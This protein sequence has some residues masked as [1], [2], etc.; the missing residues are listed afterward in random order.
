LKIV[1]ALES[2][3]QEI[4]SQRQELQRQREILDND[5]KELDTALEYASGLLAWENKRFGN[6]P[7]PEEAISAT[8]N[9]NKPP[10]I[11]LAEV[12]IQL[13]NDHPDWQHANRRQQYDTILE[14]L[15]LEGYDFGG[16]RA[17]LAVNM[18]LSKALKRMKLNEQG[19]SFLG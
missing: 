8:T 12:I 11:P 6:P 13:L 18:A 10:T 16:K 9:G 7:K 1:E 14:Q 19:G 4:Q 17:D 3:I 5:L 2:E 15:L